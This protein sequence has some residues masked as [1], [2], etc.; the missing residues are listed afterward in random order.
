MDKHYLVN[1]S[2]CR[3]YNLWII[4]GVHA[5]STKVLTE[6]AMPRSPVNNKSIYYTTIPSD[7]TPIVISII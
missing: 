2:N 6:Y 3:D 1:C 7:E 5:Y 4:P